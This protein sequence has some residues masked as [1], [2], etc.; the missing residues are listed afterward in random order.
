M[1]IAVGTRKVIA[2]PF[3]AAVTEDQKV[4]K[5]KKLSYSLESSSPGL[6]GHIWQGSFCCI[7]MCWGERM[8][9]R[10]TKEGQD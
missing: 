1:G 9:G 5:E 4:G 8:R 6:K 3:S 10:E 7:I 2:L